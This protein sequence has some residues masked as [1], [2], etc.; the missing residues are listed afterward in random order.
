MKE[1][2]S[3][4]I[5]HRDLKLENILVNENNKIKVSDFGLCTLI[6]LDSET[7]SRTQTT[8]ILKYIAPE[9]LQEKT[10]YDEKVDVYAFGVVVYQ[11]LM[12]G[13]FPKIGFADVIL[14]KKATLPNSI[15]KFSR[16]IINK[17]WSYK[18][19]DRPSFAEICSTLEG[20]EDK[21]I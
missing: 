12:K 10:K 18:A 13:E 2:H 8:G 1:V 20:N 6:S 4:G 17:C 14:G 19:S 3:V 11:I 5:I 15:S 16:E 21:L 7:M 9:L